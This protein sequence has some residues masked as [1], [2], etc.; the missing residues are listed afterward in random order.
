MRHSVGWAL[1]ACAMP[2][3]AGEAPLTLQGK[4]PYHG[5]TLPLAVLAQASRA[6]LGDIRVLNARGEPVPHAWVDEPPSSTAEERQHAVPF[7]QAPA[8]ASAVTASQQGGWIVD[9]RKVPGTLLELNLAVKPGTHGVYSFAIEAS[10][11]LQQ[12]RLHTGAAQLLSL[13]RQ[14]LRLEHTRFD[15][16]G[17][18]ARYLRLPPQT[19][20]ALPPLS[21]AKVTSVTHYAAMPPVQW[22]EPLAPTQCTAEHCDFTLPRHLPLDRLEWQLADANTLASVDL[23]VQR[24]RGEPA[25]ARGRSH[26]QRL[27]DHLRG[28]RHKD[29]PAAPSPTPD[30]TFLQR[31]TAY[32]LRLPEGDVRSQPLRLDA[33]AVTQLRVQPQGGMVQLGARPPTIRIG[34]PAATL[35]FLAREPAPFRLAWGG[36]AATAMS[37]AQLMPT[38]K[39]HD[40][41]PVD[42]ASVVMPVVAAPVATPAPAPASAPAPSAPAPSRKLWLWGVLLAALGVMGT[43]AWRLL[44]P[45]KTS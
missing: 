4:A 6:D 5:L 41:L 17:L 33:G 12:W 9:L 43:M 23:L 19:G 28:I 11:D 21:A 34:A 44:R 16:S 15:L 40:P 20:S 42:T 24:D 32:W 8:A 13:Q 22:S 7:F 3:W 36:E 39:P 35:V 1:L 45:S 27:R 38:R 18:R 37:L 29:S 30:W 14:G 26:R 10:D 25:P 2:A 31:T